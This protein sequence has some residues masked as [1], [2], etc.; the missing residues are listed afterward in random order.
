MDNIHNNIDNID[1]KC[2]ECKDIDIYNI[3]FDAN[4]FNAMHKPCCRM[5]NYDKINDE[6]KI[7]NEKM[8]ELNLEKM[9]NSDNYDELFKKW[10]VLH[11]Q[12]CN[13][14]NDEYY[15]ALHNKLPDVFLNKKKLAVKLMDMFDDYIYSHDNTQDIN[16]HIVNKKRYK[17]L[18]RDVF[19]SLLDFK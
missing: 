14:K 6:I 15:V 8:N 5:K 3:F 1:E 19:C 12:S 9:R 16:I 2:T 13:L 4:Y 17:H 10:L 11:S 7:V 18:E